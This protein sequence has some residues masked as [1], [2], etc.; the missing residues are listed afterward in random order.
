MN[1]LITS[2]VIWMNLNFSSF[3]AC[4]GR[5]INCKRLDVI[6]HCPLILDR[7]KDSASLFEKVVMRFDGGANPT[8]K[9]KRTT[10]L[11]SNHKIIKHK[12]GLLNLAEEL[13]NVSKACQ[14]MGYSRD[15]FYRYKQAVD[16]GGILTE[17][18]VQPWRRKSMMMRLVA[19]LRPHIP[20]PVR[21]FA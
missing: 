11:N 8:S 13:G 3:E 21:Q 6:W 18:Q 14:V 1:K 15:T 12:T 4:F 17:A 9:R 2:Y 10:M 19:R 7:K 20:L 16:E 5:T